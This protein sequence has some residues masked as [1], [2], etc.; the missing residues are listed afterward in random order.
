VTFSEGVNSFEK[1][2][3]LLLIWLT[4]ECLKSIQGNESPQKRIFGFASLR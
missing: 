1:T 3:N 2:N 4:N